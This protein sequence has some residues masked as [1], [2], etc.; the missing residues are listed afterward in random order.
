M[1]LFFLCKNL[2]IFAQYGSNYPSFDR[3]KLH[4]GFSLAVNTSD[5]R[6]TRAL[7]FPNKDSIVSISV[8]KQPGFTL[9]VVTSWN[10]HETLHLRLYPVQLSF[11]ERLFTYQHIINGEL[12]TRETRLESTTLDFPIML[13]LRTKRINNFAAY[14]I[15]GLQYSLD[16]ASQKDV[17]Q[18][19][20]DPIMKVRQH[21]YAYQVGG[22]FDFF[23]P[24]FKFSIEIKLAN[25]FRNLHIP[26]D[27]FFTSPYNSIYSKVWIFAIHFEG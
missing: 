7:D 12:K 24:Y 14:G 17:T 20:S 9:A 10:I 15:T 4:F 19:L 5:F 23:L 3:K 18:S 6:Y 11:Q 16:L 26:D 8:R 21:D 27:T 13:K 2:N 1:T 25:G 22:G